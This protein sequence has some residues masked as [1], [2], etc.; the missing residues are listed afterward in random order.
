MSSARGVEQ[1][2]D[3]SGRPCRPHPGGG[4]TDSRRG[5][6]S[7]HQRFDHDR[8][9]YKNELSAINMVRV[10]LVWVSFMSSS[11]VWGRNL[12]GGYDPQS[13]EMNATSS[14]NVTHSIATSAFSSM[15]E[16]LAPFVPDKGTIVRDLA[17]NFDFKG[18]GEALRSTSGAESNATFLDVGTKQSL[19]TKTKQSQEKKT[20]Q[21]KEKRKV[22]KDK[23]EHADDT[24]IHHPSE[25]IDLPETTR[26]G[27]NPRGFRVNQE[28]TRAF[29]GHQEG[30]PFPHA[31]QVEPNPSKQVKKTPAKVPLPKEFTTG[32]WWS[33]GSADPKTEEH[34]QK[35]LR[36]TG[37]QQ[38]AEA[39]EKE[40]LQLLQKPDESSVEL[41]EWFT[42]V[43]DITGKAGAVEQDTTSKLLHEPQEF[44]RTLQTDTTV[45]A[46]LNGLIVQGMKRQTDHGSE[47]SFFTI[48]HVSKKVTAE[49]AALFAAHHEACMH[50][51]ARAPAKSSATYRSESKADKP[52]HI[53]TV[54][55]NADKVWVWHPGAGTTGDQEA[56]V[57]SFIIEDQRMHL[58]A[59]TH[60]YHYHRNTLQDNSMKKLVSL[61]QLD[62][63]KSRPRGSSAVVRSPAMQHM[64]AFHEKFA[65]KIVQGLID[66]DSRNMYHGNIQP[67]NFLVSEIAPR[68]PI[69]PQYGLHLINFAQ[70]DMATGA[71][72]PGDA[73]ADMSTGSP[74]SPT[75]GDSQPALLWPGLLV[76]GTM[77]TELQRRC[78]YTR[79]YRH[80]YLYPLCISSD[81]L[82]SNDHDKATA[83]QL[84][85]QIPFLLRPGDADAWAG[86]MTLFEVL[87]ETGMKMDGKAF[88]LHGVHGKRS[89]DDWTWS[90]APYEDVPNFARS[91]SEV[92][93]KLTEQI[94]ADYGFSSFYNSA[95]PTSDSIEHGLVPDEHCT[96]GTSNYVTSIW[97]LLRAHLLDNSCKEAKERGT[98]NDEYSYT[99]A[100]SGYTTLL[101]LVLRRVE[102]FISGCE[103]LHE[104]HHKDALERTRQ[105][106]QPET[107]EAQRSKPSSPRRQSN[108]LSEEE[109][110]KKQQEQRQSTPRSPVVQ[111]GAQLREPKS[112][113]LTAGPPHKRSPRKMEKGSSVS[114]P[115]DQQQPPQLQPQPLQTELNAVLQTLTKE[116]SY[117]ESSLSLKEVGN[118]KVFTKSKSL[119]DPDRNAL[120][121]KAVCEEI[122]KYGNFYQKYHAGVRGRQRE[123]RVAHGQS[124]SWNPVEIGVRDR[125]G[126]PVNIQVQ[127]G[128]SIEVHSLSDGVRLK[129]PQAQ[130]AE[131]A[132]LVLQHFDLQPKS[133]KSL[134][135]LLQKERTDSLA[136]SHMP[137]QLAVSLEDFY[138]TAKKTKTR[139]WDNMLDKLYFRQYQAA[140]ISLRASNEKQDEVWVWVLEDPTRRDLKVAMQ[141]AQMESLTK[142]LWHTHSFFLRRGEEAA[143]IPLSAFIRQHSSQPMTPAG[144]VENRDQAAH[145]SSGTSLNFPSVANGV[146]DRLVELQQRSIFHGDIQPQ[147]VYVGTDSARPLRVGLRGFEVAGRIVGKPGAPIN[148]DHYAQEDMIRKAELAKRPPSLKVLN[149]YSWDIDEERAVIYKC[150][151]SSE[152]LVHLAPFLYALCEA[153]KSFAREERK[154]KLKAFKQ[155]IAHSTQPWQADGWAASL[156]L[157]EAFTGKKLK[158]S[159]YNAKEHGLASSP[160]DS[161]AFHVTLVQLVETASQK[162]S[163]ADLQGVGTGSVEKE[164][165]VT[166]EATSWDTAMASEYE[167]NVCMKMRDEFLYPSLSSH[168]EDDGNGASVW[169]ALKETLLRCDIVK[170]NA[171]GHEEMLGGLRARL[172]KIYDPDP[173][174]VQE[175][176]AAAAADEAESSTAPE[177]EMMQ[178]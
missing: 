30:T 15:L 10:L 112:P 43:N 127:K 114:Q 162:P 153:R 11:C 8:A 68:S 47:S 115:P 131:T 118:W 145:S 6:H 119:G 56:S 98:S 109:H 94:E 48:R 62:E 42:A 29:L 74:R 79:Q 133:D 63:D 70:A 166:E 76:D 83:V 135:V 120:E 71:A 38:K 125:N 5:A 87:I 138:E 73:Q 65:Q 149:Q 163:E 103:G 171:D 35:I 167:N 113:R 37:E 139:A 140:C 46:T 151:T 155:W 33:F 104:K 34:C 41:L 173:V 72:S 89:Q 1:Q 44:E 129:E 13:Q 28:K 141:N 164:G 178:V 40:L 97:K 90:D 161:S 22:K 9:K 144:A 157:L 172:K 107:M 170:Q 160:S 19:E 152:S 78:L 92:L 146:I 84:Q 85:Q 99:P 25:I 81:S 177:A 111:L 60:Y 14:R 26:P 2:E 12:R 3:F 169:K 100:A 91:C 150:P 67:A 4:Y 32:K 124:W 51:R 75:R 80:P 24:A 93:D 132:K 95:V 55:E 86:T 116:S 148:L 176:S 159:V 128:P 20:T 106:R 69:L 134:P 17:D 143:M 49:N 174:E 105:Q 45:G 130:D 101:P 27:N 21:A 54:L 158:D 117:P 137:S 142:K 82:N 64:K 66:L 88:T 61:S 77:S 59:Q 110:G 57:R 108:P 136:V 36:S 156:T 123:S 7:W 121:T 147:H 39:V 50:M 58:G 96:P 52:A 168:L 126:E 102:S 18:Q 175:T 122:Y 165:S 53:R 23:M 154:S 31:L 16:F